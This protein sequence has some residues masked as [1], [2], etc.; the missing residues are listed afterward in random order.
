M[1]KKRYVV[2]SVREEGRGFTNKNEGNPG[3]ITNEINGWFE[4]RKEA[5]E[6]F[7]SMPQG[8]TETRGEMNRVICRIIKSVR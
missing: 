2:I 7:D 6:K 4:T 3:M 8:Q 5:E 1:R